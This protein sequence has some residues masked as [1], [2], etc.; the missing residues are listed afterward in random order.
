[1]SAQKL[2]YDAVHLSGKFEIIKL[3]LLSC[4]TNIFGVIISEQYTWASG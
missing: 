1:M 4:L 3:I 2:E